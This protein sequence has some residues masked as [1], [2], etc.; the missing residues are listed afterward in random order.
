MATGLKFTKQLKKD[1][2]Q[3]ESSVFLRILVIFQ[4][5]FILAGVSQ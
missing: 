2:V 5:T 1:P 4:N 3:Q